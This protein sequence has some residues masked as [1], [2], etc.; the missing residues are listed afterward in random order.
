MRFSISAAGLVAAATFL[1]MFAPETLSAGEFQLA[2]SKQVKSKSQQPPISNKPPAPKQIETY[3]HPVRKFILT[4]P[5]GADITE[6][7][8]PAQLSIVSRKGFLINVQTGDTN[9]SMTLRQMAGRLEEKYLGQGK[10][11]G[12]K[13]IER[14]GIVAGLEGFETQYEGAGTRVKVVFA[15][16]VKTDFVFMFFAPQDNFIKLE[17]EFKWL[18]LNF[19]PNPAEQPVVKASRPQI[20]QKAS[21]GPPKPKR[22]AEPGYGYTIQYPGDWE[23]AKPTPTTATFS[24]RQGTDAFQVVVSIQNVQPPT[25]K[26]PAEAV[27]TALADLKSSLKKDASEVSIIGEKPLIYKNGQISLSGIQLVVIYTFAGERYRKWALVL[28]RPTGTVA[29]IWSYTAPDKGFKSFRPLVDAMLKSWT[30]K[31]GNG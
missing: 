29:H 1:S 17:P 28:P 8:S 31:H 22:F 19:Q 2:Q 18:L 3:L 4:I 6:K 25:A 15:R 21:K 26:T 5:K 12:R 9:P 24:G 30:I 10:P 23:A 7:G 11:W 13:I 20:K 16:G 14:V 27:A